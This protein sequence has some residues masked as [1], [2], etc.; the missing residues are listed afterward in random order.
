MKKI[1]LLRAIV[2]VFVCLGYGHLCLGQDTTEVKWKPCAPRNAFGLD[3]GVGQ[4]LMDMFP[5]FSIS[6]PTFEIG[7]RYAHHFTPYIGM[8][9]IKF[10]LKFNFK[11][12]RY[13]DGYLFEPDKSDYFSANTQWMLGVRGNTATFY[14]CM[15]GYWAVRAGFGIVYESFVSEEYKDNYWTIPKK[16]ENRLGVGWCMEFETGF[17]IT[18]E[19]FVGYVLS[20]QLGNYGTL[21]YGARLFQVFRIGVT[22]K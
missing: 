4:A 6:M 11:K 3:L 2:L 12:E 10:N 19:L 20:N 22:I 21:Y 5:T 18:R 16:V 13:N 1:V 9:F 15:S 14:K 17:N 8:D 7:M